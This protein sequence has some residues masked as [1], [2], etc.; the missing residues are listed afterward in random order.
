[1]RNG[2]FSAAG[3]TRQAG[4]WCVCPIRTGSWA[5]VQS[6]RQRRANGGFPVT[7]AALL[8]AATLGGCASDDGS[9]V[10]PRV[11]AE[12]ASTQLT[13]AAIVRIVVSEADGKALVLDPAPNEQA[14]NAITPALVAALAAEGFT[15]TEHDAPVLKYQVTP[16]AAGELLRIGFNG[17]WSALFFASP[18]VSGPLV[19][20]TRPSV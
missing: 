1:M 8:L 11:S 9:Y 14:N 18:G 19:V 16:L 10:D 6:R 17:S 15:F 3:Q 20:R 4:A 2:C 13:V 12:A 7:T 5:C